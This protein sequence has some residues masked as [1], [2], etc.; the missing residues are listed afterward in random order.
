MNK[1]RSKNNM[2]VLNKNWPKMYQ[3][4]LD[5]SQYKALQNLIQNKIAIV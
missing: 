5:D 2:L 3:G 1:S 4:T